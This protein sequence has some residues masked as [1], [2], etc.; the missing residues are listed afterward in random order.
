LVGAFVLVTF[1]TLAIYARISNRMRHASKQST[2]EMRK[3]I[4]R[5]A[6]AEK[7][8][9]RKSMLRRV[10]STRPASQDARLTMTILMLVASFTIGWLPPM[11]WLGGSY[12]RA[13][14]M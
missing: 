9:E 6:N 3:T 2:N 10:L 12:R 13:S 14:A 8:V 5:G 7:G 1:I 4:G 11:L